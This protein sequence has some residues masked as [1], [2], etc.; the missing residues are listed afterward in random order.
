MHFQ[1]LK[2]V[3]LW[4][5]EAEWAWAPS[6]S[7]WLLSQAL[8]GEGASFPVRPAFQV[9]EVLLRVG[10]RASVLAPWG[11]TPFPR[12]APSRA[13]SCSEVTWG[14]GSLQGAEIVLLLGQRLKRPSPPHPPK[15]CPSKGREMSSHAVSGDR[16]TPNSSGSS[17]TQGGS[18]WSQ[19]TSARK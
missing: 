18:P 7:R 19:L 4:D 10:Q 14:R 2:S 8:T 15:S 3:Y 9:A 11:S 12:C 6:G 1:S 5:G 17:C 13:V 16:A